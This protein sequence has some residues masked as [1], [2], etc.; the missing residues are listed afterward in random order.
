SGATITSAAVTKGV[1]TA[2]ELFK[3]S[4]Q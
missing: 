1:N 2:I 3:N 4:L